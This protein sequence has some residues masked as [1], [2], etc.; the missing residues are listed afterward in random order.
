MSEIVKAGTDF[1]TIHKRIIALKE[2][3]VMVYLELGAYLSIIK[4][5]KFYE[6]L[7]YDTFWEYIGTPELGFRRDTAY[8]MMK[9]YEKFCVEL[10]LDPGQV[11]EINWTKLR[12]II[13]VVNKENSEEWLEKARTLSRSDLITEVR[14]VKES[15]GDHECEW[16][17]EIYERCKVCGKK[18]K[19]END[20]K[21]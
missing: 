7:G 11:K 12:D 9:I 1:F 5:N 6:T 3:G 18:R 20:Q 19:K 13:P 14:E 10:A 17:D 2:Q 4:Q 16:E 15:E 8:R 21:D